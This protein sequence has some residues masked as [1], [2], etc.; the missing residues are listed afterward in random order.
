MLLLAK[1]FSWD[2]IRIELLGSFDERAKGL[3]AFAYDPQDRPL[4]KGYPNIVKHFMQ[5][6]VELGGLEHEREA[7]EM[8][9]L[10]SEGPTD[11][12]ARLLEMERLMPFASK[13][14]PIGS[15]EKLMEL[16]KRRA[17]FQVEINASFESSKITKEQFNDVT[18]LNRLHGLGYTD[19]S[20]VPVPLR[21]LLDA[22]T[23]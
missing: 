9:G 16:M 10:G 21:E 18:F 12:Y 17:D 14:N 22:K 5:R 15:A 4:I 23:N 20:Q 6:Y 19:L 8:G 3:T 11:E 7:R 13:N 1:L 2:W